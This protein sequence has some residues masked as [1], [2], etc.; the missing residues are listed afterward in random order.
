M[1]TQRDTST[2]QIP[3]LEPWTQGLVDSPERVSVRSG[4]RGDDGL[5]GAIA[6]GSVPDPV[7]FFTVGRRAKRSTRMLFIRIFSRLRA[8]SL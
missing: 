7:L 8:T 2:N 6:L 4:L 1:H 5:L 3:C